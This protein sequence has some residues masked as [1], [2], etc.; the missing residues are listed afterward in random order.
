MSIIEKKPAQ[1]NQSIIDALTMLHAVVG[2]GEP[3]GCTQLA[4]QYGLD[5]TRVNRILGT[6]AYVGMLKRTRSRKYVPGPGVHVLATIGLG[7]S[8][9]ISCAIPHVKS[10]ERKTKMSGTLG[11]LWRTR[12]SF[13]YF[14]APAQGGQVSYT[15]SSLF[16]AHEA[17]VGR[18][19]LA[20]YPDD[21]IR[22]QYKT[23]AAGE[24]VKIR[25]LMRVVNRV[26]ANGY[27]MGLGLN[28]LAVTI[29]EPAVAA[30]GLMPRGKE[31]PPIRERDIPGLVERM[32][33]A[34]DA[35]A[36]D[37]AARKAR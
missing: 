3:V 29:G 13:V 2:A 21:E 25:E 27:A 37:M 24:G 1:P 4:R 12:V 8:D 22:H 17:A 5:V 36:E 33:E 18:A 6:L 16:P 19:L 31:K 32:H 7:K 11:V 14:G 20:K 28:S 15:G 9:L 35:I 23:F 26:R 34:A 10:L 30:L